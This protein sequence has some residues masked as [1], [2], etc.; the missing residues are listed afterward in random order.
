MK[1]N[2][3]YINHIALVIDKSSSM[4][5]YRKQVIEVADNQIAHLAK[6]SKEL[7]QETRVTVY[8]FNQGVE[9]I[10]YD[11]DVLRL[12]SIAS[13]YRPDG[14]TALIDA[15]MQSIHD[16]AQTPELYG[17]HAFLVYVLTDG[18][19]NRSRNAP[20]TLAARIGSLPSHWTVAAFVPNQGGKHE[21]KKFGFPADNVAV[22]DVSAKGVTEVGETIRKATENFM[23]GRA[24]GTRGTRNLFSMDSAVSKVSVADMKMLD[25]L[26]FGQYRVLEVDADQPI[27]PFVEKHTARKYSMGEAYYALTK[28]ETVQANKAIAIYDKKTREVFTG[29][30]ARAILG[31]PDYEVKVDAANH[32]HFE[33]FIQSTSVNRKLIA[34]TKLLLLS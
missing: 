30:N 33:I 6:R 17:D 15:T 11:K 9:C 34:G 24:T 5:P 27:A 21:A 3:N 1:Q 2:Q 10:F 32:P 18:E 23:M 31:L 19:E 20:Q 25:R 4:D 26:H 29:V 13:H 7:D 8:T 14:A 12:P 22:W 16:L 28:K